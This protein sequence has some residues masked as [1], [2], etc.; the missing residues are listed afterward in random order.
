MGLP[1]SA[2][3]YTGLPCDA[4]TPALGITTTYN[5]IHFNSRLNSL[6]KYSLVIPFRSLE[7]IKILNWLNSS[8]AIM[9]VPVSRV[10]R[11]ARYVL[12]PPRLARQW[13]YLVVRLW[14][15]SRVETLWS[16]TL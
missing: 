4:S 16:E 1:V 11:A 8:Y 6:S 5:Y 3:P 2:S 14:I 13:A 10:S 12:S 15:P 7:L 9:C